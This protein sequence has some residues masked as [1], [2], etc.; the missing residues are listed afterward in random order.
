M[1]SG[2]RKIA[3]FSGKRGGFGAYLPLMK[4]IAADPALELQIVLGDMHASEQFGGTVA[5][6]KKY[7]P[8]KYIHVVEMG[9]G[10]GDTPEIRA[11]NLGR[12]MER[13][14]ALLAK[15]A[16]DILL[17]HGDRGE[18]LTMALAAVTLG[19]PVA[20]SQGGDISGNIDE[21]IRH[22]LTKLSHVHFP[23]TKDA[24]RRIERLGEE[25]WRIHTA[26][27]LYIDRIVKKMYTPPAEAR[28]K[29]LL[30]PD[31]VFSIVIFHPE[32]WRTRDENYAAARAVL[33]AAAAD[34]RR[35]V[36]TYPCSDP[37]YEGIIRAIEEVRGDRRFLI[38]KNIENLD[39]LGLMAS[40]AF[41]IGNSSSAIKEAP[42]FHLPAINIGK[43]EQGRAHEENVVDAGYA[44]KEL[45]RAIRH[46]TA[47]A[48]FRKKLSRCGYHLGD[49]KA[50]ERILKVIKTVPL[51][52]RLL[53]KRMTY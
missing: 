18:H 4:L 22:S 45:L 17:V 28:K 1:K 2:R 40:A 8:E 37:G 36:V 19:I 16:P 48:R 6:A 47:N 27:S 42:Y 23:E 52:R 31:D 30:L 38:Y 7:F 5:E 26:G 50:S 35:A 39:F 51:D 12:G 10:R 33:A 25:K 3:V 49:G 15:L 43:R 11:E 32:T 41:M 46:V 53:Q 29:Y 34:G 9:A 44:E 24:A 14:A 20:H 21:I 13:G